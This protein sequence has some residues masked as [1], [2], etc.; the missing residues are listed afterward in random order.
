MAEILGTTT[1]TIESHIANAKSFRLL[2]K[3]IQDLVHTILLNENLERAIF[4]KF[5][6]IL[7]NDN[8]KLL[9]H[10]LKHYDTQEIDGAKIKSILAK[11]ERESNELVR[12]EQIDKELEEIQ[13]QVNILIEDIE[14]LK[15]IPPKPLVEELSNIDIKKVFEYEIKKYFRKEIDTKNE[16]NILSIK[17]AYSI[18]FTQ[19]IELIISF[20]CEVK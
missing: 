19:E 18:D 16:K 14:E 8:L 11:V 4:D 13:K 6:S 7:K 1:R 15:F 3:S 12:N 2:P 5:T 10:E 20:L 9:E 17:E